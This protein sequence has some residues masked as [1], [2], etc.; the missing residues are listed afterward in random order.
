MP[1]FVFEG[2][3]SPTGPVGVGT[4]AALAVH[5]EYALSDIALVR[6]VPLPSAAWLVAAA[7]SLVAP[8]VRRSRP[9]T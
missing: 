8:W 2:V 7:F 9:T 3:D 5:R 1:F 6:A 4:L